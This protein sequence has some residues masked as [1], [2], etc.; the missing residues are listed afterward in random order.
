VVENGINRKETL[1]LELHELILI[2]KSQENFAGD[3][4]TRL[5]SNSAC[6]FSVRASSRRLLRI[7]ACQTNPAGLEAGAP[8]TV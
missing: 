7:L 2:F 4:V 5:I 8:G 3:E 6:R 1:L